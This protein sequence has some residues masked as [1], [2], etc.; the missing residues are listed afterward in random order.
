MIT[1]EY[2]F[3]A[4]RT[5][6]E[7]FSLVERYGDDAKVLAGGMSLVPMM[8]LGLVQPE[9]IISLNHLPN[10]DYIREDA[11]SICIGAMTRHHAVV[12]DPT[13]RRHCPLLAEAARYIGDVQVQH[14]GTI[15]GSLAHADP[16]AD[17]PPV[18]LVLGV[19]FRLQSKKGERIVKAA[20]FFQGLL[21]TVLEPGELLTEIRIPKPAHEAGTAYLRLHRV[22][23]NFAIVN[24]AAMIENGFKGARLGLAGI[25]PK[26]IL[27]DVSEHVAKGLTEAALRGIAADVSAASSEA[28]R[29][30][31]GGEDYKRAMAR[32]YAQRAVQAAAAHM[33]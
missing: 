5:L 3:H 25:G 9:A 19:Q 1:K 33:Q 18:M 21:Q 10:L 28:F 23:G 32:V 27:L 24:A 4:P 31:N 6:E 11:G 29:D 20:D 15:G 12:S 14:R 2:A 26:A 22:E 7:V 30:L 17:Y 16:A 8:T 13:I